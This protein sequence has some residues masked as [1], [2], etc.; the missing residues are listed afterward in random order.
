LQSLKRK[1]AIQ[2]TIAIVLIL[3]FAVSVAPKA[4][5]HDLVAD[6]KDLPDCRQLHHSKVF[7]YQGFN[8]HFDDLV[9]TAPFV[10]SGEQAPLFTGLQPNKEQPVSYTSPLQ[11]LSQTKE[12]RGPPCLV[13]YKPTI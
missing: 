7:H 10:S 4:W 1:T 13:E 3:V 9:V 12:S 11:A 2:K 5:F 6:H 8:C